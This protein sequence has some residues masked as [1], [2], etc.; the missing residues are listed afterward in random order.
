M[1]YR[2][3]RER[4]PEV[5]KALARKLVDKTGYN[6]ISLVSLST[7]DYTCLAPMIHDMIAEFKDERVS[8]SLPSLRIDSFSVDLAKKYRQCVKAALPLHRK[9][10]ASVCATLLIKA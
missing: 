6:E 4:H 3:V 2:P 7:A 1:V 8:V 9:Q 5:L 10:A